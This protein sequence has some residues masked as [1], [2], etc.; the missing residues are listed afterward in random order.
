M[1]PLNST[2]V[3]IRQRVRT[4]ALLV[5]TGGPAADVLAGTAESVPI[6]RPLEPADVADAVTFLASAR[7]RAITGTEVLIDGGYVQTM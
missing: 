3:R 5:A 7:A 6:G 4:S 2:A 1:S